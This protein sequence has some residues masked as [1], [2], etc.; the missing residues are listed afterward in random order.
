MRVK[1]KISCKKT[2]FWFPKAISFVSVLLSIISNFHKS[3]II[4]IFDFSAHVCTLQCGQVKCPTEENENSVFHAFDVMKPLDYTVTDL[5]AAL[6]DTEPICRWIVAYT[7]ITEPVDSVNKK[8][9]FEDI[10]RSIPNNVK[11]I[12]KFIRRNTTHV[13]AAYVVIYGVNCQCGKQI[14][15][16]PSIQPADPSDYNFTLDIVKDEVME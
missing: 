10:T 4:L 7:H 14:V 6:F 3:E 9:K 11:V 8:E 5:T 1:R 12:D 16:A 13:L 2:I 15:D